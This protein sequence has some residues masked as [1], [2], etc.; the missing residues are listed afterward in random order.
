MPAVF[1]SGVPWPRLASAGD[2][3]PCVLGV[4]VVMAG[5]RVVPSVSSEDGA[6]RASLGTRW[7]GFC[8]GSLEAPPVMNSECSLVRKRTDV[9]RETR[10]L[11]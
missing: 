8:L 1:E 3:E 7:E 11:S 2:S 6:R 9:G 10:F 4:S 5:S